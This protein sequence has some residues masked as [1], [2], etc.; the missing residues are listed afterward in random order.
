MEDWQ[1]RWDNETK[2]WWT[3]RLIP[4]LRPWAERLHGQ[5]DYFLAQLLTGHG[6]TM[7]YLCRIGKAT[8]EGCRWCK[9]KCD[10]MGHTTFECPMWNAERE[11][12]WG[13]LGEVATPDTLVPTMLSAPDKW[14]AV[15]R[16]AEAVLRRK[17]EKLTE[18]GRGGV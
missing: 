16:F 5:M 15:A 14:E 2:G 9:S 17:E 1:E 6:C 4:I 3:S 18:E 13:E 11:S 7:A 10:D 12:L 8:E